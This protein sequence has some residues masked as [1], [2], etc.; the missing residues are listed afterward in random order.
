M[1]LFLKSIDF[2]GVHPSLYIN[3]KGSY[4][5]T[6]GGILSLLTGMMITISFFYFNINLFNKSNY[7]LM[8][9]ESRDEL[10]FRN[11]TDEQIS[12]ILVDRF[13][14]EIRD[15]N[16]FFDYFADSSWNRP[17]VN[18]ETGDISYRTQLKKVHL[19]KCNVENHFRGEEELW[20]NQKLIN[21]SMCL[22]RDQYLPVQYLFGDIITLLL[23]SGSINVLIQLLK[24]TVIQKKI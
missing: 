1:S 10:P 11:W 17:F 12:V 13:M 6:I 20:K 3:K 7:N 5:S 23:I 15:W 18:E 8:M 21:S 14:K 2:L 4:Q 24:I 16:R 19:E 9:I 22:K